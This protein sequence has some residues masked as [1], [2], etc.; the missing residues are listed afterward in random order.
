MEPTT[1]IARIHMPPLPTSQ[2]GPDG[3]SRPPHGLVTDRPIR[4]TPTQRDLALSGIAQEM[5]WLLYRAMQA[6]ALGAIDDRTFDDL[7]ARERQ[8]LRELAEA[9]VQR[10]GGL[11]RDQAL[12][13]TNLAARRWLESELL[14]LSAA[15]FAE[16]GERYASVYRRLMERGIGA[17]LSSAGDRNL[18]TEILDTFEHEL[19]QPLAL[20][21]R[22]QIVKAAFT[23][24]R[25][26]R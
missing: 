24:L 12:R 7:P 3:D 14:P 18:V 19:A 23:L 6:H 17:L 10:V 22:G 2:P 16:G 15:A 5:A 4:M 25:G 1:I 9:V 13:R 8:R 26:E 11:T 20:S 21:E